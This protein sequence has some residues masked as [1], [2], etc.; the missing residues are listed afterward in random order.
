MATLNEIYNLRNNP[1]LLARIAAALANAADNV[2]NE[3]AATGNH[4]ARFTWAANVLL[5]IGGAETEAK[6]AVWL[7]I[8][9]AT[10]Q[11]QYAANPQTGGTVT[12]NDLQF[13]VNGM[14]GIL[15]GVDTST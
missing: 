4:S 9:N 5:T 1:H 3:S 10:I 7:I 14:V 6:R 12:D 2:R 8:Q 11:D 15:S 13:V